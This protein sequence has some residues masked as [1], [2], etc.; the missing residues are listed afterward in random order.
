M[1][2]AD[3]FQYNRPGLASPYTHA[4]A[5]TPHDTN[6]LAYITR[7]LYVGTAGALKVVTA[8]GD[9]VTFGNVAVGELR[10][11]VKQ[12]FSTGT[13]ASNIVSMW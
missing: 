8:D 12:V 2:A 10:I 4:A 1:P 6:E 11:R 9:T 5:V 13:V 7:A 3:L